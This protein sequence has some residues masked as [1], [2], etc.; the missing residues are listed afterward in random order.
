MF[1]MECY[2]GQSFTDVVDND[3]K[4]LEVMESNNNQQSQKFVSS[5]LLVNFYNGVSRNF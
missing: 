2:C 5:A 4:T 1:A 3:S